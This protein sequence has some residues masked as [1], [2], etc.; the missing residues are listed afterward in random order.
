MDDPFSVFTTVIYF[1]SLYPF[2]HNLLDIVTTCILTPF[3]YCFWREPNFTNLKRG[4]RVLAKIKGSKVWKSTVIEEISSDEHVIVK[5]EG[6]FAGV[7]IHDIFPL[8]TNDGNIIII[9]M[10]FFLS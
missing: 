10:L 7:P 1:Q 8:T 2:K 9:I 3:D 4:S 5:H 6:N